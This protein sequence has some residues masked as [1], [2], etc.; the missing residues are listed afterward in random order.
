MVAIARAWILCTE[1][2]LSLYKMISE[3]LKGKFCEHSL[4][5]RGEIAEVLEVASK[6]A[7]VK[8]LKVAVQP[9]AKV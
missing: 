1:T 6:V 7:W 4:K 5:V 9:L 8:L 3:F 2:G